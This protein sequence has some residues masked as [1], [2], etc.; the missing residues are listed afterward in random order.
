MISP[1]PAEFFSI[2][3]ASRFVLVTLLPNFVFAGVVA[4]L[5]AAGAPRRPSWDT[6]VAVLERASLTG[7][8]LFLAVVVV[9]S[10]AV[11]PLNYSLVQLMEGHW[12]TLTAPL[13]GDLYRAGVES[14][15]R[16]RQCFEAI[17][18][19][20]STDAYQR[21]EAWQQVEWIPLE[22]HCPQ[23]WAML[24]SSGRR[25]LV[26]ATACVPARSGRDWCAFSPQT[27]GRR[28]RIYG[29]RWMPR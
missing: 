1:V 7:V 11:Y 20:V 6:F 18:L 5:V 4:V 17:Y 16:R 22:T 27:T 14:E 26:S 8:L 12:P 23:S 29:T 9:V 3:I 21:I 2:R 24:C 15:L 10:V 28:S 25:G 19:R 13:L